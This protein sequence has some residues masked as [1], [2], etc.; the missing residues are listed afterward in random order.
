MPAVSSTS[1]ESAWPQTQPLALSQSDQTSR[2]LLLSLS[3]S[4]FLTNS[5]SLSLSLAFSLSLSIKSRRDLLHAGS[6]KHQP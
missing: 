1:L 5:L 3:L 6:L 4:H 2:L